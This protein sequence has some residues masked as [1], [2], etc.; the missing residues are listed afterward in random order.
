MTTI[1]SLLK[2]C[3]AYRARRGISDSYLSRLLF[4]DGK[5][6]GALRRGSDMTSR[7]LERAHAELARLESALGDAT[8]SG[9]GEAAA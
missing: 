8:R 4:D 1:E 5:I 7:R 2:R 9:A 3:D 6:I